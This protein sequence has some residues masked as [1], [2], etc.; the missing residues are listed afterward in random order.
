MT[1]T[2]T[3]VTPLFIKEEELV[4]LCFDEFKARLFAK[5]RYLNKMAINVFATCSYRR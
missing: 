2:R 4:S 1:I 3:R 5:A